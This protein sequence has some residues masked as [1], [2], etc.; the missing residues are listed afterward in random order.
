MQ[1]MHSID[2]FPD[3][4]TRKQSVIA[5]LS[6][7][8]TLICSQIQ[9]FD[10]HVAQK[11]KC[12]NV[13]DSMLQKETTP[14][15]DN[16]LSINKPS[17]SIQT[18]KNLPLDSNQLLNNPDAF[19]A[20]GSVKMTPVGRIEEQ[21]MIDRMRKNQEQRLK[22]SASTPKFPSS[23]ESTNKPVNKRV[24][25]HKRQSSTASAATTFQ[26]GHRRNFS[27]LTQATVTTDTQ[28][29]QEDL[30]HW[31]LRAQKEHKQRHVRALEPQEAPHEVNPM[32]LVLSVFFWSIYEVCIKVSTNLGNN[33]F[34]KREL[35]HS[36]A[37]TIS[38]PSFNINFSL[39][40]SD[41]KFDVI[42]R[43]LLKSPSNQT[44]VSVNSHHLAS[45]EGFELKGSQLYSYELDAN[46]LKPLR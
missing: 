25:G 45:I 10:N 14:E 13:P 17:S 42:E 16:K 27:T 15:A 4:K 11:Y 23:D 30:Y 5:L 26:P 24:S 31:I 32:E 9:L 21:H 34:Q 44:F 20:H 2:D 6:H 8:Q 36:A 37:D 41:L 1:I 38:L 35:D 18:D 12:V 43:K 19:D 29:K 22:H 7:W 3:K 40:L 39:L 33:L 46:K 28:P